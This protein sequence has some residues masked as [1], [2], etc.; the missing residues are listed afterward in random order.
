[1]RTKFGYYTKKTKERDEL[2]AQE[3]ADKQAA[4]D[5][6]AAESRRRSQILY[7]RE[8]HGGTN[9]GL[10][11]D[12]QQSYSGDALGDKDLGFGIGATTGGPV[13]NKTGKGR[14][15]YMDGGLTDLVDIYD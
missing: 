7:D 2:R 3:E 8:Q 10:G 14:T 4:I 12:N 11:S 9:Y 5:A 13:S 15:D 6:A 1:M